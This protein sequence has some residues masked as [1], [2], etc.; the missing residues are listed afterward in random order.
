MS[1]NAS[2]ALAECQGSNRLR[3]G[4]DFSCPV[5][6]TKA[7]VGPRPGSALHQTPPTT[8]GVVQRL[9]AVR[10]EQ[11]RRLGPEPATHA[12]D[13]F[14]PERMGDAAPAA[15]SPGPPGPGGAGRGDGGARDIHRPP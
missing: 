6:S 12:G 11:G 5:L 1:Q 4:A 14:V 7:R 15:R 3:H 9:L 2:T 10:Y 8:D 13:R